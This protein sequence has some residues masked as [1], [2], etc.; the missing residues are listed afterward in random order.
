MKYSVA[1]DNDGHFMLAK[2]SDRKK[3]ISNLKKLDDGD[4][5][6]NE[7]EG[8][9]EEIDVT[10]ESGLLIIAENKWNEFVGG[11]VQRGTMEI[12]EI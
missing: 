1:L 8:Y 10:G 12:V 4:Y 11:F 2:L 5:W 7:A 6:A 9:M 3:V